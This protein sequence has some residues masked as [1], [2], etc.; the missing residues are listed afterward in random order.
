[1]KKFKSLFYISIVLLITILSGSVYA[2]NQ[3]NEL[4]YFVTELNSENKKNVNLEIHYINA[5]SRIDS[6][7]IRVGDKSI[8]V[9]GGYY[10]DAKTDIN[11]VKKLGVTKIDYY[12]GSHAHGDHVSAAGPIIKE[13]GIKTVLCSP[14][15]TDGKLNLKEDILYHINK[16][17]KKADREGLREALN[18][19]EFKVLKAGDI[20]N[21]NDLR[22][23]CIGPVKIN[24]NKKLKYLENYN[25]LILRL[26]YGGTSFLLT[27]DARTTELKD[28]KKVYGDDLN[29]TVL[30]N[31]HHYSPMNESILKTIKPKYVVFTT[32]YK[33]LPETT[34][35]KKLKK[36]GAKTFITT[37]NKDGTV[38]ATSDGDTLTMK[39]KKKTYTYTI[40]YSLKMDDTN[41]NLKTGRSKTLE[42]KKATT[43]NTTI[44][45]TS[46]NKNVA[47]VDETGKV[48]G[49]KE[50]TAVITARNN[51]KAVGCLVTVENPP[52]TKPIYNYAKTGNVVK[53]YKDDSINVKIEE[54]SKYYVTKV[55]VEEPYKQ[56]NKKSA[57]WN[58][59]LSKVASLLNGTKD[60]I[61]GINGSGYY[62][63][64]S[65]KKPT[66]EGIKSL[67]KNVW[68]KTTEGY[69]VLTNGIINR[70]V[71]GQKTNALLGI[72]PNGALKYYEDNEYAD[73]INDGVRN[74][75]AYG[76]LLIKDGVKYTQMVG[77]PRCNKDKKTQR[78]TIGQVDE[79]NYI[80]ITTKGSKTSTLDEIADLGIELNAK[81]LYNLC[82]GSS[83]T[84]WYRNEL[85]KNGKEIRK[86]SQKVGDAIYF[87]ST[88]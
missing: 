82:G 13:F 55:W 42:V 30:K 70:K 19:C 34:Y 53:E 12:I 4:N 78:S 41:I 86:S 37:K 67:G 7:F 65:G 17:A 9:D 64:K 80:M 8:F 40:D 63:S 14:T 23:K 38:I 35:L 62:L 76:P 45:W 36:L 84:L 48:T 56:I 21:V 6:M 39:T 22:I 79:N 16:D 69:L 33:Y 60:G 3:V 74:T 31:A 50:G 44:K 32:Y 68:D 87:S 49:V 1:M 66:E 5:N 25:S 83:T 2:E 10:K 26:D 51:I 77:T 75:F 46:S 27:G 57:N 71:D 11:Y 47:T 28:T 29:V 61:V 24:T 52:E 15:Q 43:E 73:V 72:T 20:V 59:S 85:G 54:I 58:K 88:L 18:A 81:I